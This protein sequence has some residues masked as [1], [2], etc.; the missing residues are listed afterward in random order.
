MHPSDHIGN[1]AEYSLASV[2]PLP[3]STLT[4][5]NIFFLGSSVT[6]GACSMHESFVDFLAK[7]DGINALKEAVSGTT[8]VDNG[9]DSYISRMKNIQTGL[10]P[11]LFVCQLSTNDATQ[12]LP[13]DEVADAIK[14]IFDYAVEKWHVPVA[15]YTSPRYESAS[16][17]VLVN[18]LLS[19]SESCG[20]GLID[21]WN[22]SDF[23]NITSEDSALYMFDAI[24]PTRAGYL[25]WWTPY[26]EDFLKSI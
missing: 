6:Y 12:N 5:K 23:N 10:D 20:F 19:L 9:K 8:L 21:M 22:D 1:S 11:D 3:Y 24:H 26:F 13:P 16:Y 25:K 7:R 2:Q 15:F 14:Y 18:R 4:G 17:Q